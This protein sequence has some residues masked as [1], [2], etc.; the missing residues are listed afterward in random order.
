VF[1]IVKDCDPEPER[2]KNA[3]CPATA[4]HES[5]ALPFVIPRA[6]DFFD[7]FVFSA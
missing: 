2:M 6:C 3:L 7:L 5:V 1:V 4:L